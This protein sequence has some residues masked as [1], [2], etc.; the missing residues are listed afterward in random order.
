MDSETVLCKR[1]GADLT[2]HGAIRYVEKYDA[3]IDG[4]TVVCALDTIDS[5]ATC[6]HCGVPVGYNY[7]EAV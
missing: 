5:S 4:D 7:V 3:Y 2:T 6:V 1:C